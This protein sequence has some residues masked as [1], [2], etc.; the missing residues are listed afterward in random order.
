MIQDRREEQSPDFSTDVKHRQNIWSNVPI[1]QQSTRGQ[2][3]RV[4]VLRDSPPNR[5]PAFSLALR[6]SARPDDLRRNRLTKAERRRRR[7]A[8]GAGA[9]LPES[10]AADKHKFRKRVETANRD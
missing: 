10:N 4:V 3:R 2:P 8:T 9:T 7:L 6:T 5:A 1:P